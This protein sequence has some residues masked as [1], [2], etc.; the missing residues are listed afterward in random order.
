MNKKITITF[1]IILI[2]ILLIWA[3]FYFVK[4]NKNPEEIIPP[5]SETVSTFGNDQLEEALVAYLLTQEQ[6][7]WKIEDQSINVCAVENLEPENQLFPLSV[8]VY[9][10]EYLL[11]DGKLK[12]VSGSSLPAKINYPN[13]LSFYDLNKFSYEAPRDGSFNSGDIKRIF[14]PEAQQNISS[15]DKKLLIE[16]VETTA[17][18]KLI[19]KTE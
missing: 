8:W 11:E 19:K 14:S 17:L 15:L 10:G 5:P 3:S 13:E 4:Q 7:S 6:F 2:A 18:A 9:C 12:T 16:K 1:L